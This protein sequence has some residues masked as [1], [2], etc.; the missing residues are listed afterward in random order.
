MTIPL[1]TRC[2]CVREGWVVRVLGCANLNFGYYSKVASKSLA[3][4][5]K[6]GKYL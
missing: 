6:V 2:W 5:T 1:S 3:G 4:E